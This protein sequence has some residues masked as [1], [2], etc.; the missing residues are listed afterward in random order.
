LVKHFLGAARFEKPFGGEESEWVRI[1]ATSRGECRLA[2]LEN[3]AF[4][5]KRD[6]WTGLIV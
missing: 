6:R 1:I 4:A 5:R 2:R 3:P